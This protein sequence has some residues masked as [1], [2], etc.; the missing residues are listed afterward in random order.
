MDIA[1]TLRSYDGKR[2]APFRAVAEAVQGMPGHAIPQLLDLAASEE[3]ALEVGA[4]GHGRTTDSACWPRR[5]RRSGVRS[6]SCLTRRPSGKRPRSGR[7]FATR[8]WGWGEEQ[9]GSQRS[10]T[11]CDRMVPQAK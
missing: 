1:S 7:A 4:S 11:D 6:K 3:P 10:R 9:P 2:V 8:E 5:I